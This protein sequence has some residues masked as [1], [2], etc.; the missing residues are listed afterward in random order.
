VAVCFQRDRSPSSL[1]GCPLH[2]PI[3]PPARQ[4]A[5][6]DPNAIQP[7][8]R[9]KENFH[10]TWINSSFLEEIQRHSVRNGSIMHAQH[11]SCVRGEA[12]A[13]QDPSRVLCSAW[14]NPSQPRLREL[15]FTP[16]PLRDGGKS[17][18]LSAD[19]GS[20]SLSAPLER[21]YASQPIDAVSDLAGRK[22]GGKYG[23]GLTLAEYQ[24]KPIRRRK[25]P[26]HPFARRAQLRVSSPPSSG[27]TS[28][29]SRQFATMGAA[30]FFW[31]VPRF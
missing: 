10:A 14:P 7:F 23:R 13:D 15:S 16:R 20:L 25:A 8:Y 22:R 6:T 3:Y 9:T 30:S 24:R 1:C 4:P 11:R 28:D 26:R 31:T 5:R 27:N 18:L 2:F 17:N 12:D 19:L 29:S 21:L